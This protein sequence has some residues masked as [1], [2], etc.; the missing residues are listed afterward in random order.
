MD[1]KSNETEELDHEDTSE[2]SSSEQEV[3][4]ATHGQYSLRP[5]HQENISCTFRTAY[6]LDSDDP[7]VSNSLK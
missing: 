7:K 4:P 3:L 2:R 5:R 1:S 6:I